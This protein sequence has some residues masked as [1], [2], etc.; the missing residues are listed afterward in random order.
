[1]LRTSTERPEAVDAGYAK[2]MGF[3]AS[4]IHEGMLRLAGRGRPGQERPHEGRGTSNQ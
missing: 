2:V 3:D 4:A 1:M